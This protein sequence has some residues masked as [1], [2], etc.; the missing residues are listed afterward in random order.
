MFFKFLLLDGYDDFETADDYISNKRTPRVC[1]LQK[2]RRRSSKTSYDD[3][4]YLDS[5]VNKKEF[6][7][8]SNYDDDTNNE[9]ETADIFVEM[10][11]DDQDN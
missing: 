7:N 3:S 10:I 1:Q 6:L 2:S 5:S 4:S 11:D 9:N 8:N